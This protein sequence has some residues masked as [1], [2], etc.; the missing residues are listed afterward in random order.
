MDEEFICLRRLRGVD[1][2]GYNGTSYE[3]DYVSNEEEEL[4]GDEV[5]GWN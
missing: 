1:P 5:R 2:K 4:S 3:Q